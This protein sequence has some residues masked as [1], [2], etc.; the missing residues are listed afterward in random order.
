MKS[1]NSKT[2]QMLEM[3]KDTKIRVTIEFEDGEQSSAVSDVDQLI[4]L[5]DTHNIHSLDMMINETVTD[6]IRAH[7]L[8]E[9]E[10]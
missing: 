3:N 4:R 7:G 2:R 8:G 10:N 9:M 1:K 6:L 5:E